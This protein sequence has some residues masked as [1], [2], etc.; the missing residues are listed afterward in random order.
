MSAWARTAVAWAVEAGIMNGVALDNGSRALQATRGLVRA[1][2]AA[3]TV[4]AI[5]AG[6]LG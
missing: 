4:S 5:D 6:M 1:E 2:M 3:M